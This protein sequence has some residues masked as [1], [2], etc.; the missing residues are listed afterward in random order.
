MWAAS[1]KCVLPRVTDVQ[2]EPTLI[3]WRAATHKKYRIRRTTCVQLQIQWAG[4]ILIIAAWKGVKHHV[5]NLN[6]VHV[7]FL[8]SWQTYTSYNRV[9]FFVM[10]L[11]RGIRISQF[12]M[13]WLSK[14]RFSNVFQTYWKNI[15]KHISSDFY[16]DFEPMYF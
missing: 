7:T 6:I 14:K 13:W 9:H 8:N 16:S 10:P 3:D 15:F 5:T 12:C 11:V 1:D 2:G 4:Y